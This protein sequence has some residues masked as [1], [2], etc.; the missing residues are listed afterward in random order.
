M[1]TCPPPDTPVL[2]TVRHERTSSINSTTN[3]PTPTSMADLRSPLLS[4]TGERRPSTS[5]SHAP[6]RQPS[7]ESSSQDDESASR[8]NHS[9]KRAEE[10]PRNAEGKMCCKHKDCANMI[11]DRK[12][13]WR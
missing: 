8:R 11:F 4:P 7:E 9:Y 10:P 3:I 5:S 6:I 13:E 12:C 2:H 1:G